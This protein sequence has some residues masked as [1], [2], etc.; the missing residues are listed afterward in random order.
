MFCLFAVHLGGPLGALESD[1]GRGEGA[2][3][4]GSYRDLILLGKNC[5][6]RLEVRAR[7]DIKHLERH[8]R[9]GETNGS[10]SEGLK[11]KDRTSLGLKTTMGT[12]SHP[13]RH[14]EKRKS[15]K[16]NIEENVAGKTR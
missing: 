6:E 4:K 13:P 12:K 3:K 15:R 10:R 1:A 11:Q 5:D 16:R 8:G 14:G 2:K 9:S 7:D